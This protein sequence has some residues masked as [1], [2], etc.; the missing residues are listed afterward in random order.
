MEE[1]VDRSFDVFVIAGAVAET[2]NNAELLPEGI[3]AK[4]DPVPEFELEETE[5]LQVPVSP[6]HVYLEE[7]S[8][9]ERKHRLIIQIA[10]LKHISDKSEIP[11]LVNTLQHV[12]GWFRHEEFTAGA[13]QCHVADTECDPLYDPDEFREK[14][15]FFG[16]VILEIEAY[17]VVR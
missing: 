9:S 11:A 3:E 1:I 7:Q 10:F 13:V 12:A 4:A 5:V 16:V 8:R 6:S 17:E 14:H 2:L 15:E